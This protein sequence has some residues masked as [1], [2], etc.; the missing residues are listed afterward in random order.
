MASSKARSDILLE[1]IV[2]SRGSFP[3]VDF[4]GYCCGDEGGAEF[5]EAVDGFLDFGDEGVDLGG[6]AVEEGGD[7]ALF[8]M[9]GATAYNLSRSPI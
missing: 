1:F 4:A 5:F 8:L 2:G 3:H 9:S 7:G 6:F